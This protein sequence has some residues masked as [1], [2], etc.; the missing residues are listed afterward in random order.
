MAPAH[1]C[2]SSPGTAAR[3]STGCAPIVPTSCDRRRRRVVVIERMA[4][5]FSEDARFFL[6]IRGVFPGNG[7]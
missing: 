4:Y 3:S 7:R 5:S 1:P 6:N 2:A